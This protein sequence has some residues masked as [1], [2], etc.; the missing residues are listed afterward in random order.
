MSSLLLEV[1]VAASRLQRILI[2]TIQEATTMRKQDRIANQD[3]QSQT[4]QQDR[5]R[6][7][8]SDSERMRG[9]DSERMRG[10]DSERMRGSGSGTERSQRQS[11]K[12]PLPD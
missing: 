10:S 7:R 9:S 5:E 4:S 6:M 12:L 8:G 11:G 3:N 1:W 2:F